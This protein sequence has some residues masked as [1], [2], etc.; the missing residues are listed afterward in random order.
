MYVMSGKGTTSVGQSHGMH[1]GGNYLTERKNVLV[2]EDQALLRFLA[3][4]M[5]ED[6]GYNPILA[7]TGDEAMDILL[8]G[9][10]VDLVFSDVNMPGRIN[11]LD[12]AETVVQRWPNIGVVLTS[13][14][15]LKGQRILP[16]KTAFLPKPYEWEDVYRVLEELTH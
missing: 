9:E 5:L 1:A 3:A 16:E 13:G 2:V 10:T 7:A 11:G 15:F 14:A 4:D 8:K 6:A 12:L